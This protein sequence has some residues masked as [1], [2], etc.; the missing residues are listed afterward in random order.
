MGGPSSSNLF[1]YSRLP[2]IGSASSTDGET[3]VQ[4]AQHLCRTLCIQSPTNSLR[5]THRAN[6]GRTS[7]C[8]SQ[9]LAIRAQTTRGLAKTIASSVHGINRMRETYLIRAWPRRQAR[10]QHMETAGRPQRTIAA[11]ASRNCS[12][13]RR[14]T[15]IAVSSFGGMQV[16]DVDALVRRGECDKP[17]QMPETPFHFLSGI[18]HCAPPCATPSPPRVLNRGLRVSRPTFPSAKGLPS[19]ALW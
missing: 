16:Q 11:W 2:L 7:T 6:A 5:I 14:D 17:R 10:G 12:W 18:D 1:Y 8:C 3:F 13:G 9:R 19:L 15:N 4:G